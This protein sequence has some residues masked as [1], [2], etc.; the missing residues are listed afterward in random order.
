[1][2]EK[3]NYVHSKIL[4]YILSIPLLVILSACGNKGPLVVPQEKIDSPME[5][6]ETTDNSY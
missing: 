2:L 5:Q 4:L 3:I 6:Q 1:M